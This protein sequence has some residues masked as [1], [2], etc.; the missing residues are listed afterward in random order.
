MSNIHS[1]FL[2]FQL[3]SCLDC[4]ENFTGKGKFLRHMYEHSGIGISCP[5]CQF[6]CVSEFALQRHSKACEQYTCEVCGRSLKNLS[7][8][9][10]HVQ[11]HSSIKPF[12]CETCGQTFKYRQNLR[13]HLP[14]HTGIKTHQCKECPKS[15]YSNAELQDHIRRHHVRIKSHICPVCSKAFLK[16]SLLRYHARTHDEEK[17]KR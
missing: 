9:R 10:H 14:R 8:Y 17:A 3:Y 7:S 2:S 12:S 6:R 11:S 4:N 1:Q 15:F 13:D 5:K 16:P